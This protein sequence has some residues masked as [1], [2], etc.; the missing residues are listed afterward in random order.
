[1]VHF[2]NS[3]WLHSWYM[4]IITYSRAKIR[5]NRMETIQVI[6]WPLLTFPSFTSVVVIELNSALRQLYLG[7]ILCELPTFSRFTNWER[8]LLHQL[9]ARIYQPLNPLF[10]NCINTPLPSNFET[11]KCRQYP[12]FD[13]PSVLEQQLSGKVWWETV[14]HFIACYPREHFISRQQL[15]KARMLVHTY[16]GF[17]Q[18]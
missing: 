3:V 9:K 14:L 2:A 5:S 11:R 12:S 6:Y 10:N 7:S 16:N 18:L 15:V 1:M 13:K 8:L 17:L 4:G